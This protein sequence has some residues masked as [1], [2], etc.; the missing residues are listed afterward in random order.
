MLPAVDPAV[1]VAVVVTAALFGVTVEGLKVQV[2]PLGPA[3]EK[4]TVPV[5]L[6]L[7]VMVMVDVPVCEGQR[8]SVLAEEV[9]LKSGVVFRAMAKLF[10]SSEPRPVARSNP[11][12]ALYPMTPEDGHSKEESWP[13][14][15]PGWQ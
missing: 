15:V 14:G 13:V 9:P 1:I 2:V 8:V 12:E 7:G 5:K 11:V 3:Q 6:F 10:R 4:L